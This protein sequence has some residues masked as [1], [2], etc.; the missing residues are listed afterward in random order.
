MGDRAGPSCECTLLEGTAGAA[1]AAAVEAAAAGLGEGSGEAGLGPDSPEDPACPWNAS[2]TGH[3]LTFFN[4]LPP[5]FCFVLFVK[6]GESI[7]SIS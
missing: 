7:L 1:A 2:Q 6:T 5:T 4:F 3:F